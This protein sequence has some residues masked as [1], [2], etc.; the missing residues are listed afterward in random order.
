M[1][2]LKKLKE[3][4]DVISELEEN[5]IEIKINTDEIDEALEKL[6]EMKE[7]MLSMDFKFDYDGDTKGD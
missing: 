2:V 1:E 4:Q 5:S 3:L 7:L 6:R